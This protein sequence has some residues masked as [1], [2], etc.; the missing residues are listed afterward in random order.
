MF[1]K[2]KICDKCI[3]YGYGAI[4]KVITA[5][6]L[7]GLRIAIILDNNN[8][9][10]GT[11]CDGDIRRGLLK[12]LTLD[13][14]FETLIQKKCIFAYCYT[15]KKDITKLMRENIIS[16][17]PILSEKDEFIGLEISDDLLPDTSPPP[18]PNSA[19]LMAG[20][21]GVRLSPLT[22]DCPKPL[23]PINGKPIL[24]IILNQ[25]IDA[26]ISNF[27][28]SVHYLSQMIKNYFG[29]G[30][31]WGI[32]IQY[33]EEK[34]PLGTAGSLKLLPKSLNQ[35]ILVINGDVLNKTNYEDLFTYHSRNLADITIC[36]REHILTSPYGVIEI[37]GI[38][39]KSM[40]E[41]PSFKQLVNAGIYIVNPKIIDLI[42]PNKYLDMP[43]L[44]GFCKEIDKRLIV[45][46]VHEYWLDIGKPEALEKAHCEWPTYLYNK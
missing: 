38:K 24:E 31:K 17:I 3:V 20:G 34:V 21:R 28:I 16:Q 1:I 13:S 32:K 19:L 22:D 23:L 6:E 8:K 15:S 11:I 7:G 41:K 42:E 33:L 29:D 43:D 12:G 4:K 10:I 36:A 5:I 26:G 27:Y 45:Y 40:I 35:S 39:F 14:S 25:C 44:I 18:L 46:P 2:K 30:S 37:E 9:L